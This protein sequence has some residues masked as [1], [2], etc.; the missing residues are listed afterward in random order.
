[1][2]RRRHLPIQVIDCASHR[3]GITGAPFHVVLFDDA[4]SRKVGIVFDA[5][6]HC[7]VL[8]VTELARGIIAFGANSYRGDVYEP[9][10]RAAIHDFPRTSTK[11]TM[12]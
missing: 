12:P 9:A 6:A 5:S 11:D 10:L 8:D 4:D 2:T 1:M 3:N 7:A